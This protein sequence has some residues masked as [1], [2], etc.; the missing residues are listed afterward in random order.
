MPE[1]MTALIS[2]KGQTYQTEEFL[3]TKKVNNN[4]YR[5]FNANTIHRFT[6]AC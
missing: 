4:R 5:T 2:E 6:L 1:K 3:A